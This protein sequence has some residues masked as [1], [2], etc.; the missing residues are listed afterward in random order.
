MRQQERRAEGDEQ[1]TLHGTREGHGCVAKLSLSEDGTTLSC[2]GTG[3]FRVGRGTRARAV[4]AG[5]GVGAST[6]SMI[7]ASCVLSA[8]DLM[9]IWSV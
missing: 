6:S 2:G 3:Y 8:R 1:E 7:S 9:G 5:A 4:G